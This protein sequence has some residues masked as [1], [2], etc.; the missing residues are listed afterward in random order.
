VPSD[1][2]GAGGAGGARRPA[3]DGVGITAKVLEGSAFMFAARIIN[4]VSLFVVSVTLARYLGLDQ[5]GLI[6]L[7]T[8]VAGMLEIV[9]DVGM[10]TGA[11]RYIPF[12]QARGEVD[13]VRRVVHINLTTKAATAVMLGTLI[14]LLAGLLQD[15]FDKPIKP[16]VEIASIVLG[17]NILGGTFQGLLRG[18]QRLGAMAMANAV[19]DMV[20]MTSCVFLVVVEGLG[21]EGALWGFVAGAVVWAALS[22]VAIV[23]GLR[24]DVPADRPLDS[25]YDRRVA[26][27]LVTFG[28]PVLLSNLLFMVFDWTDTYVIAYFKPVA[29][30]S[31]YN[32]AFGVVSIPLVITQAIGMAMLPAMSRA[33]GSGQEGLM[34]TLWGGAL[35]LVNLVLF[36]ASLLIIALAVP[37]L[38]LVYGEDY[39]AGAYP[40]MVLAVW[41]M[42][43]PTGAMSTH[44]LGAMALQTIILRVNI[45]CVALNIVLNI[46]LVPTIGIIGAAY[47]TT[48]SFF[49]NSVLLYH[50]AR[51]EAG[52]RIDWYGTVMTLM[53]ALG[54]MLFAAFL[55][56]FPSPPPPEPLW[57]LVKLVIA[58]LGGLSLYWVIVRN[59]KVFTDEEMEH[60]RSVADRSGLAA[61]VLKL[62]SRD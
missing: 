13:N 49:V 23:R 48:T 55:F 42:F 21:P 46:A 32:V 18:L 43:R 28:V 9:G 34:R 22:V 10:N 53:G 39:V 33:Y 25:R 27:A 44:I 58:T 29:D 57:L 17:L 20:W 47:A 1:D 16:L 14:F 19:R 50:Y 6:A 60:M 11:A 62:V 7:A 15:F 61:V 36:P 35:K 2:A 8:G 52:V 26:G 37:A 5:Y 12:Y 56:V 41:L 59:T 24:A 30:V 45:L 54:A 38:A 40:M 51:R 4:A 31:V 3:E